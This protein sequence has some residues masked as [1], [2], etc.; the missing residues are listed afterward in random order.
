MTAYQFITRESDKY[1]GKGTIYYAIGESKIETLSYCD[2]YAS[3]GQ[4]IG[5]DDASDWATIDTQEAADKINTWFVEEEIERIVNVG[6][7]LYAY[8]ESNDLFNFAI[9]IEGVTLEENKVKGFTY[10]DGHNWTSIIVDSMDMGFDTG[11]EV[12]DN[13]E[14]VNF[15]NKAIDEMEKT[16]EGTGV[17]YY[18]FVE[19]DRQVNIS[20][21]FWQ[22]TWAEYSLEIVEVEENEEA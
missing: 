8:D 9:G 18:K 17:K 20:E 2:T 15:L 11:F 7:T 6:D 4:I 1:E 5:H 21:S 19:G 16:G 14:T 13:E 3:F 22:G 10:W 12:E